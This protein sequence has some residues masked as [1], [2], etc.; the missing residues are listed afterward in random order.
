VCSIWNKYPGGIEWDKS[1]DDPALLEFIGLTAMLLAKA[2]GWVKKN[3]KGDIT[4]SSSEKPFRLNQLI[5]NYA[6]GCA[7]MYGRTVLKAEDV[8]QAL[9]LAVESA[10]PDRAAILKCILEKDDMATFADFER[11]TGKSTQ[12]VS[13]T[14]DELEHLELIE[15]KPKQIESVTT[16]NLIGLTHQF[17][18]LI[19]L[20]ESVR[21]KGCPVFQK[22]LPPLC[23]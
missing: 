12:T 1:Q 5:Y 10:F 16:A 17:K 2:R 14:Y 3:D 15:K 20:C 6:R 9:Y 11:A 4:D 22:E 18:P 8:H 13:R 23:F 21:T 19:G 7:L